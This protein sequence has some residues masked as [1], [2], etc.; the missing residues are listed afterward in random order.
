[1]SFTQTIDVYTDC[2]LSP[3]HHGYGGHLRAGLVAICLGGAV[4][5]ARGRHA[6]VGADVT[7]LA[8]QDIVPPQ[9]RHLHLH[10][11]HLPPAHHSLRQGQRPSPRQRPEGTGIVSS[12]G[13]VYVTCN[14]MC[15]ATKHFT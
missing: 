8:G 6:P 2:H 13:H 14:I 10:L 11:L 9:P 3:D 15:V 12:V 1:M 5:D 7:Q 4:D